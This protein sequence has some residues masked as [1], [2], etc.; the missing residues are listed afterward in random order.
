MKQAVV[1]EIQAREKTPSARLLDLLVG[2]AEWVAQEE[3]SNRDGEELV[4]DP[5]LSSEELFRLYQEAGGVVCAVDEA[6][7]VAE[8]QVVISFLVDRVLPV[9][10][11]SG[12]G[13]ERAVA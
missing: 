3:A 6:D 4:V 1:S 12:A 9:V 7:F 10:L 5:L 13:E 11:R 8:R 2:W